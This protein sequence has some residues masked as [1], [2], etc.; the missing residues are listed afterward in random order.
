MTNGGALVNLGELSK[1]ATVLI[2]KISDAIGA[3]FLPHQ[4]KRVAKAEAEAEKIRVFTQIE[5]NDIQQRAL[6][7]MIQDEGKKQEN[8]EAIS[9]KA[10]GDLEPSAKPEQ[11]QNDWLSN[12]FDK[13]KL[14]SDQEMQTV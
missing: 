7:R 8:I 5:I 11:L 1:P 6:I 13:C 10:I 12:F 14:V 4:I 9:A 2:E 3:V